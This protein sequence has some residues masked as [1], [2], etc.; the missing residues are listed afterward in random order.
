MK[1]S[2]ISSSELKLTLLAQGERRYP[3]SPDQAK[4]EVF[5]NSHSNRDY[6]IV[7][8]CPEFTARCPITTQPDFGRITIEYVPNLW[9]IESKALKLY[10]FSFRNHGTF[11]E[12]A[13]NRILDDLVKACRPRNMQVQG[14]FN[15]RGGIS[16]V[17]TAAYAEPSHSL[18]RRSRAIRQ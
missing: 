2:A 4:V 18:R 12:A 3:E 5:R 13:V 15:A 16:I 17:V 8:D 10:L 7:F 14:S 6:K 9:C 1:R 11:H